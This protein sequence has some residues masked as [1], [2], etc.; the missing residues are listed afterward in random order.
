MPAGALAVL[1]IG[2]PAGAHEDF[3]GSDPGDGST[4]AAAPRNVRLEF[5]GTPGR[6]STM[7]VTDGCDRDVTGR[8]QTG[9]SV[10]QAAVEAGQPGAWRVTFTVVSDDGHPVEGEVAFTVRGRADCAAPSETPAASE[11]TSPEAS[12]EPSAEASPTASAEAGQEH[13]AASSDDGGSPWPWVAGV[14]GG[15][16]LLGAVASTAYM[17]RTAPRDEG[18][19]ER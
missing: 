2:P 16:V 11:P 9:D 7:L 12:A 1:M 17:R 15:V 10:L 19:S 4:V 8:V 3:V 5:T 13:T 18:R 14:A 6:R